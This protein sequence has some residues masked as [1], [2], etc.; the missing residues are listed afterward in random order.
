MI[1]YESRKLYATKLKYMIHGVEVINCHS[2]FE[3]MEMLLSWC[4]I[5][6]RN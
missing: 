1:A 5:L 3:G 2:C 6:D 4:K